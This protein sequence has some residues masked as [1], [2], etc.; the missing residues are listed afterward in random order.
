MTCGVPGRILTDLA[1]MRMASI[2][3][4]VIASMMSGASS[5]N[6]RI[7]FAGWSS[8]LEHIPIAWNPRP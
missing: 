3:A 6:R 2:A 1:G 7:S 4:D 8:G 5:A